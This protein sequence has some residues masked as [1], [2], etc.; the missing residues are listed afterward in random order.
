MPNS[1]AP[2]SDL[3]HFLATKTAALVSWLAALLGLGTPMG[4]INPTVGVLSACWLVV[5]LWNYF[6]YTLPLNKAKLEARNKA[7]KELSD[8]T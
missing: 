1:A 3:S 7:T 4:W 5:Q 8:A 2:T 6:K